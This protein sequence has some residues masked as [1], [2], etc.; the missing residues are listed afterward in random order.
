[1]TAAPEPAADAKAGRTV[2]FDHHDPGFHAQRHQE[3]AE[4]R[5]RCPVAWNPRYGGFWAVA[6]YDGVTAV[7]RDNDVFSS[8]Y[9]RPAADGVDLLGI[10]GIPR[11][12][13][14]P[15]AG[16]AEVEGAH[17]AALRRAMNPFV[18]PRA[19]AEHAQLVRDAA[20]WFLDQHVESGTIDLVD[21]YASPV[22]AVLTM[23]IIGLPLDDW[24]AYADLFHA[25]VARRPDDPVHQ[26]AI[27]QVP[28]MLATLQEEADRRRHE[29]R[30]DLLTAL[31]Q[32][33]RDGA[34]L[35]D[36]TITSVLWNLVGGG[37]D[38]TTS[39]TSL[40]LLHLAD[41]PELRRQLIDQPDLMPAATDEFLRYFSVN[42]SLSRTVTCDAELA[43][44]QL[45]AGD[46]VLFSWLSANRDETVFTDPDRVILD[47]TPNPHVAFGVG[48]HRCIGMHVAR[49]T[50]QILVREV[51]DRIPDYQVAQPVQ[52]YAGNPT[53]NGLVSL[54]VSFSP[55]SRR[56]PEG[57]P[58]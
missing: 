19:V 10:A 43:G 45:A 15:A 14:I 22:P 47:R 57:R 54:P 55:G 49:S 58:F 37:L 5:A 42:E 3:W 20:R 44:V 7:S 13:G 17:H 29:P 48:A 50:F 9:T 2:D 21:D 26:Q 33:E 51:L 32:L 36:E 39:L 53:L 24:K 18:L 8:E 28:G 6:G 31:V 52:H 25:T 4:L 23:A 56:G 34:P 41:H 11:P 30:D 27:A 46:R 38:T 40:S 35:D 12:R 16:I 1:M